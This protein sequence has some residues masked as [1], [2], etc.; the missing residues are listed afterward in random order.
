MIIA[1]LERY[2]LNFTEF[3][4][5]SINFLDFIS[6]ILLI[7]T[8][9]SPITLLLLFHFFIQF[10]FFPSH[11]SV[12]P[13]F[14]TSIKTNYHSVLQSLIVRLHSLRNILIIALID[15]YFIFISFL[16]NLYLHH[17]FFITSGHCEFFSELPHLKISF[18]SIALKARLLY[19]YRL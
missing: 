18:S 3:A 1:A 10:I 13:T 19:F 8:N 5:K 12:N 7:K 2:F 17:L 11:I 4:I 9:F 14:R 15:S 6:F 16:I